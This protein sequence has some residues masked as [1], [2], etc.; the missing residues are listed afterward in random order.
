MFI[1][2]H[3]KVSLMVNSY[4][5]NIWNM[6]VFKFLVSLHFI[7]GVLVPFFMD[8]GKI[9]FTQIM[10]LQSW[11][12]LWIF[13][14]EVPTGTIADYFGRKYSL[15]LGCIVNI[16][17]VIIYTITPN[18]YLF[19]VGEFL[20]A[21]S[22]ALFSG[23]DDAFVY[24]SLK[25]CGKAKESKK[26]LSRVETFYLAGIMLGAPIGSVIASQVSLRAP[27]YLFA[28]PLFLAF[29][30]GLTF[31]EPV[32]T[33]KVESKKYFNMLKEGIN[34]FYHQKILRILAL[35]MVFIASVGYF[36]IWLYQPMLKQAEVKIVY[37]G[38]VCFALVLGQILILNAY[39]RLENLL[40]S[41]KRLLFISALITGIMFVVGGLT[42]YL[43]LVL[44]SI[45]LGG[46]F[47]LTRRPLF[48]SYM[49]KYIPSSKRAIVLSAVS[50]LR[51]FVLVIIN[52]FVGFLTSWSLNYTLIMLGAA[53]I[54]FAFVSKIE[55]RHLKD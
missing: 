39:S 23:A 10:I 15:L 33:K 19:L 34:F 46:G 25:K 11:F 41:K 47:G 17:T 37:Y 18:F 30:L 55:E 51:T 13:I 21:T 44:L 4:E 48:V 24:D 2:N 43:P 1:N 27:M 35:D 53:A 8:W 22:A 16:I 40:N 38:A 28:V 20:W 49:N 12:M 29:I 36:M 54:I 5:S 31:K 52:P 3:G 42:T 26:I 50:M 6:Y 7:G 45:I 9:S 32:T 14:M